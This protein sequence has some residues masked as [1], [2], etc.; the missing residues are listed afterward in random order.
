MKYCKQ[1]VKDWKK[2]QKEA[3]R[4]R[5]KVLENLKINK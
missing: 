1:I 4:E 2:S 5:E 3:R